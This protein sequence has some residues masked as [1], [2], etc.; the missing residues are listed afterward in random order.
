M[1]CQDDRSHTRLYE[2]RPVL[3]VGKLGQLLT[4]EHSILQRW[5]GRQ[6][7]RAAP[8]LLW[9][10]LSPPPYIV[11]PAAAGGLLLLLAGWLTR[12]PVLWR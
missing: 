10:W 5:A 2:E 3:L 11:P 9:W 6:A 1:L 8:R 4:V 12:L 7:G